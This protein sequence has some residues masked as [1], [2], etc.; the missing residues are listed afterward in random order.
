MT[1]PP[2]FDAVRRAFD[3]DGGEHGAV[4][5]TT[6]NGTDRIVQYAT[7]AA[8]K[9]TGAG[10]GASGA[11]LVLDT[12]GL[13]ESRTRDLTVGVEWLPAGIPQVLTAD[14]LGTAWDK[15]VEELTHGRH[16]DDIAVI[17]VRHRGEDG[18]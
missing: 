4:V 5:Y 13:V 1:S 6:T 3:A 16:D 8:T 17:H 7:D 11:D 15:L 10:F 18:T 14:D 2:E 9:A 12:D